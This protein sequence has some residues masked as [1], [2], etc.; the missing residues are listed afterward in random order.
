MPIFV[1]K[2]CAASLLP[3]ACA[4]SK[5]MFARTRPPLARVPCRRGPH[6]REELHR[7]R[8]RTH[9]EVALA[10]DL[11]GAVLGIVLAQPEEP[12]DHLL[13]RGE[14]VP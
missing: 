13:G 2:F 12:G 10:R 11:D 1:W 3:M 14:G 8:R 6:Q 5:R 9:E 4:R 7:Q